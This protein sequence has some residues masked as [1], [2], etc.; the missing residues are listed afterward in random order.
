MLDLDGRPRSWRP[1]IE[2]T[3]ASRDE[4][5]AELI[6]SLE[7]H[8]KHLKETG[9]LETRR[10]ERTRS[11]ILG[12]LEEQIA[13]Y[14]NRVVGQDEEFKRHLHEVETRDNDPYSLVNT[15]VTSL[16]PKKL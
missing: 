9:E 16:F 4:G 11:E 14:V 13:R 1:P 15:I 8:F 10:Q 7:A 6:E 3:V 2:R 5:V 12:M